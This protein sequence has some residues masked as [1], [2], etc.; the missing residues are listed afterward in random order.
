[1]NI[2]Q[3]VHFV[4]QLSGRFG[5][6]VYTS[7]SP[8]N[9]AA[10]MAFLRQLKRQTKTEEVLQIP[11]SELKVTV[12]DLETTGFYPQKGDTILSV[13]AI[14]LVG[15]NIIE[16]ETYYSLVNTTKPLTND[17]KKLTGL[18]EAELAEAPPLEQVLT[19]FYQFI[20]TKPL[21]AHHSFH[22]KSFMQHATSTALKMNF[23][24]RIMDTTFLTKIVEPKKDL[25]S[26]D[27]C[28]EHFGISIDN[29]HH[30]LDDAIGTAKLWAESVRRIQEMGFSCLSDVYA[31]LAKK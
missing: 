14:K 6:N 13:G 3:M 30:A 23:Q 11:F 22:E 5:T 18:D 26:L 16:D 31:Y 29:R 21:V 19:E 9:D 8:Q 20:D 2:N 12:F 4:K 28:C 1:M 7:V 10:S 17:I 25:I 15:S 27:A 24:H